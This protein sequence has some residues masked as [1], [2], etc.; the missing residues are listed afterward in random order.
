VPASWLFELTS[1]REN[2]IFAL[3]TGSGDIKRLA[4]WKAPSEGLSVSVI[5]QSKVNWLV[6]C[7]RDLSFLLV[8]P[9]CVEK[10]QK[11]RGF[12]GSGRRKL[13]LTELVNGIK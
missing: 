2:A 13:L 5:T 8:V 7:F 10:L 4:H 6:V 12:R 3:K 1:G 11:R 9:W